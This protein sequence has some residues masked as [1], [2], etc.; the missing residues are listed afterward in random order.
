MEG[1]DLV[2]VR[3][4]RVA[5]H[6]GVT[7]QERAHDQSFVV[8]LAVR[9]DTREAAAFDDLGA[10]LDYADAVRMVTEVVSGESFQLIETL[11]DRIARKLLSNKRV[12]DVWVRVAKP[13]A[14]LGGAVL[15]EVAVE[16]SRSRD[17]IDGPI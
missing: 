11:A 15:D 14:P 7:E 8:S 10:T 13:D 12:L 4:L 6:H 16:I 9:I 17:D 1:T 5:G 2:E 3:G